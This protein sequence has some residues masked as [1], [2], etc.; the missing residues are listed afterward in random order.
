MIDSIT[1]KLSTLSAKQSSFQCSLSKKGQVVA[2]NDHYPELVEKVSEIDDQTYALEG[3]I[4]LT[5]SSFVFEI[6]NLSIEPKE[7]AFMSKSL[8]QA[9]VTGAG[10]GYVIPDMHVLFENNESSKNIEGCEI[11]KIYDEDSKTWR[12]LLDFTDYNAAHPQS[13]KRF[14]GGYSYTWLCLS[15]AIYREETVSE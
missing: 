15:H 3:I 6:P 1:E 7:F 2:E 9:Y 5:S 12:I 10:N 13:P 11:S 8:Q 14:Q 4:T